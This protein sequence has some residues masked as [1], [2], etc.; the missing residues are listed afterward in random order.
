MSTK[1]NSNLHSICN[2]YL[3]SY[4]D[5]TLDSIIEDYISNHGTSTCPSRM[6]ISACLRGM[7]HKQNLT[8]RTKRIGSYDEAYLIRTGGDRE[9]RDTDVVRYRTSAKI[10]RAHRKVIS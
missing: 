3:R 10:L 6:Q 9:D 8:I 4:A 5:F 1:F 2:K 7:A